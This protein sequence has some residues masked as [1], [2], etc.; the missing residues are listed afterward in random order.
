MCRGLRSF[1][2]R[3]VDAAPLRLS[4]ASEPPLHTVRPFSNSSTS[5]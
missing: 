2:T 1:S 3:P 4:V 5:V